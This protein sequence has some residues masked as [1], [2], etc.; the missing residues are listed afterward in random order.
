MSTIDR[1]DLT[2]VTLLIVKIDKATAAEIRRR[3]SARGLL[4]A[5]VVEDAILASG[6]APP[7]KETEVT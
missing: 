3:A 4:F 7:H 1:T 5:Q 6:E 2:Q